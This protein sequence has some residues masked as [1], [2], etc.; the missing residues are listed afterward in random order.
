MQNLNNLA[1]ELTNEYNNSREPQF[2]IILALTIGK[3]IFDVISMIMK[4]YSKDVGEA[5]FKY[6]NP[7]LLDKV[8]LNGI[9]KKHCSNKEEVKNIRKLLLSKK[10]DKH[11]FGLVFK[12]V[13]A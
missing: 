11:R 5:Y 10:L 4:C 13:E 7:T 1:E 9:I 12:E 8:L 3:I 6:Q 2:D